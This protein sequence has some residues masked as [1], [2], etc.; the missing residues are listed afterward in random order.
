MFP[1]HEG[2]E[3]TDSQSLKSNCGNKVVTLFKAINSTFIFD[4]FGISFDTSS[5]VFL[6]YL[7]TLCWLAPY[8]QTMNNHNY[9]L[10]DPLLDIRFSETPVC[11]TACLCIQVLHQTIVSI[12]WT[13][14][15]FVLFCSGAL[16]PLKHLNKNAFR[17][18]C[19]CQIRFF[20]LL[21]NGLDA[22]GYSP[23][24]IPSVT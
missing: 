8:L 18:L 3:L 1:V 12:S 10:K 15:T 6:L 22:I 5:Y 24:F 11:P 16:P 4:S 14:I 17:W 21:S 9:L 7:N 23:W 20:S 13:P 2:Q 19:S